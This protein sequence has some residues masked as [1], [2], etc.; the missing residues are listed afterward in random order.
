MMRSLYSGVTGLRT[1]QTKMDVIGNNIANVNTIGFKGSRVTFQEVLTQT[2]RGATAP[3][4]D[5]G[6]I[7]PMQVGLGVGLGSVEAIHSPGNLQGT[8]NTSDLALEGDGFFVVSDGNKNYYTRAGAFTLDDNAK[9]VAGNTGMTVMGWMASNG[10]ID[11]NRPL[12]RLEI[13]KGDTIEP[14]ATTKVNYSGNL[15]A[16]STGKFEL[17]S[18]PWVLTNGSNTARLNMALEPTGDFNEYRFVISAVS[19]RITNSG[20]RVTPNITGSIQLKSDG[21]IDN[22]GLDSADTFTISASDDPASQIG[23]LVIDPTDVSALFSVGTDK[24]ALVDFG[25]VPNDPAVT[26]IQVIDSQG[27]E[28]ELTMKFTKLGNNQW[29]WEIDAPNLEVLGVSNGEITFNSGG[30]VQNVT[31]LNPDRTIGTFSAM[32]FGVP[33]DPDPLVIETAFDKLSQFAQETDLKRDQ[34]GFKAGTL[35]NY[36]VDTRGVVTGIYSNGLNRAIGQIAIANFANPTGL[37]RAPGT[38]FEESSNSGAAQVGAAGTGGRGS[39]KPS[40]LEMSNVDLSQEFT[41]M[42]IT[43]RGFQAN[44][45]IIT[46]SDEMLQEIVNLRR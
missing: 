27:N 18:N 8:S 29:R 36:L 17:K 46:T 45:R 20:G 22:I 34:N 23:D 9:L 13:V 5:K 33:G 11:Q 25:Y 7:N 43:Q 39:I 38:L 24:L 4:G 35:D 41:E 37:L 2:L 1:H 19:G 15:N 6:G 12:E 31:Y 40:T 10:R 16:D 21:S 3:Q 30:T 28:H 44:S 26:A 32:R 42:I 14:V